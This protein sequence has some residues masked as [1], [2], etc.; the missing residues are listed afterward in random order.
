MNGGAVRPARGALTFDAEGQEG[1]RYHSRH[2]HVPSPA[3][4]LTIGRGYDMKR[5]SRADI[6]DD[7]VA[8]GIEPATAALISQAAGRCGPE[9]EEF[10]EENGLEDFEITVEQQLRLFEI[11]Y[12]RQEADTRRLATK[13]DVCRAYGTTDWDALDPL[14]RELLVDLRFRGDYTPTTRRFLQ[15][16]VANNDR[17]AFARAMCERERWQGV[18]ADRFGRRRDFC[19]T[20]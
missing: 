18:P 13:E 7:L 15:V 11:E 9:A 8:A 16:H 14:I 1:G 12:A 6:R 4:G 19:S 20:A 10:I 2:F 5:R 17:A 3:S